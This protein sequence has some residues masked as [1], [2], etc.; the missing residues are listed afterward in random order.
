[1]EAPRLRV[2][3]VSRTRYRLPLD[4]SLERKFAALDEQM[5]VRVLACSADAVARDDETFALV[6]P[7]RPRRF[8]PLAWVS[9]L[10]ASRHTD[11]AMSRADDACP[12]NPAK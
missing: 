6:P 10:P 9:R 7:L 4:R 8:G 12:R 2:L 1:M 11:R 3:F 5:D